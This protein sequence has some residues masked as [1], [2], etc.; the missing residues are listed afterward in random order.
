MKNF[1]R[2]LFVLLIAMMTSGIFLPI[3]FAGT[4]YV[5]TT[6]SD[7]TGNG[8]EG[9][10][11]ATVNHALD[12]N[13]VDGS[14]VLV[15]PGTYNGRTR[16]RGQYALG[17][18]VRSEEPY[19]ARLRHTDTV[20]TCFY[21]KG[22]TLEGFDIAH[23]GSGA[24]ALVIQIQDLLEGDTV[25]NIVIRNNIL[26][27]SYNNDILKINNGAANVLVEG[28]MF[29]NQAG[30]DEHIDVNSVSGVVI[31]DN[32]F[33]NDFEGSGR[34]NYDTVT[35]S[36]IVVKDSDGSSGR[37][38]GSNDI[39]IRRNIFM[40]WE[41]NSGTNFVLIGEDGKD[42]FEAYDVLVENNLML[43]NS[44]IVM[45]AP[46]GVKGGKDITFRNNTVS[47]DLP[48]YAYA[49]RLNTEGDN[50]NN[51]N[52]NFFNNIWS[53]PTGTMGSRSSNS[54]DNDFSDTPTDQ[55]DSFQLSHNLYWNGGAALPE[56]A[57][58][59]LINYTDD[60]NRGHGGSG[61]ERSR[62]HHPAPMGGG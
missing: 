23:S 33:F 27:D 61:A 59:D 51:L 13:V 41:G 45:R 12:G 28:N 62:R 40:N 4:Y 35:S 50:P 44:D 42:Y 8:S 48:S 31:Q 22:I 25:S 55:T 3:C 26:H 39:T 18:I 60:A 11:W 52:V 43:G 54:A 20:I 29:Y 7:D 10:P 19:K 14:L 38:T 47:G 9:S 6:G 46:F 57:A 17:V 32:I 21:G 36:F 24:G 15:K 16:L 49:M 5:S 1:F 2:V 53:D 37:V 58:G 34:E 56:D 30:S